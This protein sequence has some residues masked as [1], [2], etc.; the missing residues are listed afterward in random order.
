[1]F[2]Q[3]IEKSFKRNCKS[4]GKRITADSTEIWNKCACFIHNHFLYH[5]HH[6][7]RLRVTDGVSC[8]QC[9][10]SLTGSWVGRIWTVLVSR[11]TSAIDSRS[12]CDDDAGGSMSF[13][14][15][16]TRMFCRNA[17]PRLAVPA[18]ALKITI[19]QK[20]PDQ[21]AKSRFLSW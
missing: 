19:N 6:D 10:A 14:S 21:G 7:L 16:Y 1:M 8:L 4:L 3:S 20:Q 5:R 12:G 18:Y 13:N 2:L 11:L 15:W 17:S 9:F